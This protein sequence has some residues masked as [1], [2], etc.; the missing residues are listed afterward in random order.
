MKNLVRFSVDE[1]PTATVRH[2]PFDDDV[3]RSHVTLVL[4]TSSTTMFTC[5]QLATELLRNQIRGVHN[6]SDELAATVRVASAS[7]MRAAGGG[8]SSDTLVLTKEAERHVQ[9][10]LQQQSVALQKL[11][12]TCERDAA[13]VAQM[14]ALLHEQ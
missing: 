5:L 12:E 4:S 2:I 10:F 3:S 14:R 13:H 8:G 7:A 6:D 1:S 9:L 11:K